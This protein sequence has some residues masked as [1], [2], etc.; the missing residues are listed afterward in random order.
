[1]VGAKWPDIDFVDKEQNGILKDFLIMISNI[2]NKEH[3]MLKKLPRAKA[4][5][6][7]DVVISFRLTVFFVHFHHISYTL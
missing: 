5:V 1:M 2:K 6:L 7:E 3:E 4:G